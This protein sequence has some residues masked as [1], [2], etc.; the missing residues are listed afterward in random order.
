MSSPDPSLRFRF[1]LR[2]LLATTAAIAV[3]L[4]VV[5]VGGTSFERVVNLIAQVL[6]PTPLIVTICYGRGDVR[7]FSVGALVPCAYFW[8]AGSASHSPTWGQTILL[9]ALLAASGYLAIAT[10]RCLERHG[11]VADK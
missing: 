7:T 11:A 10:R 2:R 3:L 4:A 9:L 5:A 8:I 1:S 6:L